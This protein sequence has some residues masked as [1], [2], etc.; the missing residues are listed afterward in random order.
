M[1]LQNWRHLFIFEGAG[2]KEFNKDILGMDGEESG[3]PSRS[4]I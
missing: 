1:A 4:S 3:E 2:K